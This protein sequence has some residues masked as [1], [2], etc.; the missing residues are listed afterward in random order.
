MI[1]TFISGATG[2]IGKAFVVECAKQKQNL[3]LTGRSIDKLTQLKQQIVSDYGIEVEICACMLDDEKSRADMFDFIDSIDAKFDKI[4]NVAGVDIQKGVMDYTLSKLIFQT[5]VNVEATITNTYSL[6][7]RRAEKVEVV[8]ISSMSGVSPM[9]YFALYSATKCCLTSFFSSLRLELKKDGYEKLTREIA[10]KCRTNRPEI[11]MHAHAAHLPVDAI[12]EEPLAGIEL[13]RTDSI[14]ELLA[15]QFKLVQFRT[16][17][18]PE[19]WIL[20]VQLCDLLGSE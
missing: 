8:T 5:R 16:L 7:Q 20:H 13:H 15:K 11:V 4:I 14:A 17:W 9:P 1:Y 12:Q 19:T 6:L 3:F 10:I 2:G 18:R